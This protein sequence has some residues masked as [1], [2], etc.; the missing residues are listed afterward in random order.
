MSN[1]S[2]AYAVANVRAR[3]N[4]LLPASFFEQLLNAASAAEAER[5]I[6]DKGTSRLDSEYMLKVW[7]YIC[8]IAPEREQ[9][10]F[11]VVKNDFHNLKAV[12]K[13]TAAN[14]NGRSFCMTPCLIEPDFLYDCVKNK[15]FDLLPQWIADVAKEGYALLT[16]VMDGRLLDMFVDKASLETSAEF[17]KKTKVL[18]SI[19]LTQNTAAVTDIKIAL[20]LSENP[21]GEAALD[22]AFASCDKIDV[23]ALKAAAAKGRSE[24]LAYV[25]TT[26]YAF[27]LEGLSKSFAAFER[28][29]DDFI[30]GLTDSAKRTGF[31]IE[32]LIA[33]YYAK[34]AEYKNLRLI[35]GAKNADLPLSAIKERMREIYV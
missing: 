16:S 29:C 27:L 35:I 12:L 34:E 25:E 2:Y 6:A 28:A 1:T 32:P 11:L 18:F 21:A 22:Y 13:G 8:E 19:E 20:R 30:F 26:E 33:Y 3:E 23:A 10:E 17:A 14:E 4:E 31:G 15:K 9:V 7:D 24:V 5:M